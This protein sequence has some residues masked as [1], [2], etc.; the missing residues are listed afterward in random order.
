M[1]YCHTSALN[2]VQRTL[3][4]EHTGQ[5]L[6][7]SGDKKTSSEYKEAQLILFTFLLSSDLC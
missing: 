3:L 4:S 1:S 7:W 5:K 2:C 6:V